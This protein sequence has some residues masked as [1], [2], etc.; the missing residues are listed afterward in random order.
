MT[1]LLLRGG[2]MISSSSGSTVC[3]RYFS[4]DV[5]KAV[6][7]WGCAGSEG[8]EVG[9]F[10]TGLDAEA[11]IGSSE[12]SLRFRNVELDSADDK[13]VLVVMF[14]LLRFGGVDSSSGKA[15]L[16]SN[17]NVELSR[18]GACSILG[19]LPRGLMPS[20]I[21]RSR[22]GVG[23]ALV[24]ISCGCFVDDLG[25]GVAAVVVALPFGTF[26]FCVWVVAARGDRLSRPLDLKASSID[27]LRCAL[28]GCAAVLSLNATPPDA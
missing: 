24:G 10:A 12:P 3:R 15:K 16:S 28:V 4:P 17:D 25:P 2:A 8:S 20:I 23:R 18:T 13:G 7:D 27:L 26:A 1:L 21:V 14:V 22:V 5:R 6:I 19:C 9:V 11:R